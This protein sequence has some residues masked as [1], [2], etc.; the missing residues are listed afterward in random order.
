MLKMS[1]GMFCQFILWVK[2]LF[3]DPCAWCIGNLCGGHTDVCMLLAS[4]GMEEVLVKALT[5]HAPHVIQ[6]AAYALTQYLT[7]Y[8]QRI[9]YDRNGLIIG[10]SYIL[11]FLN[12]YWFLTV[13]HF[14]TN[15]S[16]KSSFSSLI[17]YI[18][19]IKYYSV[20]YVS[21]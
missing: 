3:Q 12:F 8:C 11:L 6:S 18:R 2:L 9:R 1:C 21:Y 13:V 5:S 14:P 15:A 7:T 17:L 16:K 4:Q 19:I 10:L 20:S